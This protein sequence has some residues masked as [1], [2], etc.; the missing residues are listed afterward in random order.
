MNKPRVVLDTNVVV[1]AA[2]KPGGLEAEIVDFIAARELTLF[3]SR[4]VLREYAT[5]LGRPKFSSI[6]PKR[7][8]LFVNLLRAEATLVVPTHRVAVSPDETDNRFLECAEAAQAAYLITGNKRHFPDHWQETR[9][10]NAREF[11]HRGSL[12]RA[13]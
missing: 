4:A 13:A 6:D 11:L 10:V 3:V 9:I 7:V 12:P 5:V 8:R 1:S 2:L